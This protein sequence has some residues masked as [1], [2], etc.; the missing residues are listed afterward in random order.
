MRPLAV[1]TR[2]AGHG[3]ELV[4]PHKR[5][6]QPLLAKPDTH[7]MVLCD[8]IHRWNKQHYAEVLHPSN[9]YMNSPGILH[10]SSFDDLLKIYVNIRQLVVMTGICTVVEI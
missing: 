4:I 9:I 7:R 3:C 8:A 1:T 5:F 6:Y 2:L 10:P